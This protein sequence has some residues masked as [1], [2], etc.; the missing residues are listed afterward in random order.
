[1]PELV[2]VIRSVQ[3]HLER[4]PSRRRPRPA[5]RPHART[6]GGRGAA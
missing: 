4:G 3:C 1:L 2:E 5:P 6:A